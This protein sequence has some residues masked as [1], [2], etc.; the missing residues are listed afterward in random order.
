M[1]TNQEGGVF[2]EIAVGEYQEEFSTVWRLGSGLQRVWNTR[3]EVP[4]ISGVLRQAESSVYDTASQGTPADTDRGSEEVSTFA[5]N[6][7]HLDA[8]L[9][10]LL[11]TIPE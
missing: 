5:V 7:R 1:N 3:R 4:E 11:M 9:H 10:T 2:T 6:S 8:S